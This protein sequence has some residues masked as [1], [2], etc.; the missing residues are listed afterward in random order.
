MPWKP[1]ESSERLGHKR[2]RTLMKRTSL[3]YLPGH[4]LVVARPCEP[5]GRA[6]GTKTAPR[7]KDKKE[8]V[9]GCVLPKGGS[10]NRDN[11]NLDQALTRKSLL[12]RTRLD[13]PHRCFLPCDPSLRREGRRKGDGRCIGVDERNYR[14]CVFYVCVFSFPSRTEKQ[15]DTN[16]NIGYNII[17]LSFLG[18]YFLITLS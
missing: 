16:L 15:H 11:N 6:G 9:H 17:S 18:L 1:K 13:T 2:L 5:K 12:T 14:V 8:S 10:T 3:W 7:R 4:C